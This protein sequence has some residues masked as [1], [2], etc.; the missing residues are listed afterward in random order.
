MSPFLISDVQKM[1]ESA[2]HS[3]LSVVLMKSDLQDLFR[4]FA[5]RHKVQIQSWGATFVSQLL[6]L[7]SELTT[8]STKYESFAYLR[9]RTQRNSLV[10]QE[11]LLPKMRFNV[12]YLS[13]CETVFQ[14]TCTSSQPNDY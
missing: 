4:E 6:L 3:D 7:N 9:R 11:N 2:S 10:D 13:D 8:C 12:S 5:G 14:S 1:L